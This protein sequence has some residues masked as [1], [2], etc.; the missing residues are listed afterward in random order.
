MT[1]HATPPC[2]RPAVI[3][4]GLVVE[5][6]QDATWGLPGTEVPIPEGEPY[7]PKWGL[8]FVGQP[9]FGVGVDPFGTYASG[10][11]SFLFS[12][13]LGNHVIGTAA[14]VTSRF[15]E[16]GGTLF[17][18]NRTHRWNWGASLD[19]TPY[20]SRGF[21]AAYVGNTYVEREYRYLQ[22]D[23]SGTGFLTYPF[24]RS[25]RVEFSGGY[26]RIGQSYD[27]TTRTYSLSGQ[28]LDEE[29]IPL[30]EYPTLNL[31]EASTALVY[32]TSIFGATSPIRG[33]RYRMEFMQSGGSLTY[34][35]VLADM[36]TYLMPVRPYTIALR[37]MYY[38]RLGDDAED[39]MLPALYL[40]Y[41][42]LV[43]GYDQVLFRVERVRRR[44]HGRVVPCLRPPH[45][46]PCRHC[47]RRA[48]I[49]HLGRIRRHPVLRTAP[50]RGRVLC[51]CR[52]GL[53]PEP[54]RRHAARRPRARRE[55]RRRGSGQHLQL[56]GCRDRFRQAARPADARLDVAVPVQAGILVGSGLKAQG[57]SKTFESVLDDLA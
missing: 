15:D 33:S 46:Q 16:F 49:P 6:L 24:S 36:R 14:Q 52:R 56:R 32:D 35:G 23:Q 21:E 3:P 5:A 11:V 4:G 28:Q 7:K 57:S 13:M 55:P 47:Q 1:C 27:L 17:Y 53:G 34:S 8:D 40:G 37:G 42:G 39:E 25:W 12:D 31:G 10:G 18:L 44:Q 51:G 54:P 2:C 22:R 20:V 9:S 19:Q 29:E 38:G 41:P 30:Q 26:R 43:R 45:R 50:D 48:A